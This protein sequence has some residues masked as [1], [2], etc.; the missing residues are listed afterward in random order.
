MKLYEITTVFAANCIVIGVTRFKQ[1]VDD[2]KLV[3]PE[4]ESKGINF[5]VYAK[6]CKMSAA[7][8]EEVVGFKDSS[9][10]SI[11]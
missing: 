7:A 4:L 10:V 9:M 6:L 5:A 11:N 1:L 2:L 8:V 3:N